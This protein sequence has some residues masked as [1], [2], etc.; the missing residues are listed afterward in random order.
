MSGSTL[1]PIAAALALV[2]IAACSGGS[3]AQV[4]SSAGIQPAVHR[5]PDAKTLVYVSQ[6][7]ANRISAFRLDGK[8]IGTIRK[9]VDYPQGIFADAQGT[10]YIANRGASDVLEFNRGA[11]SPSKIL[12]DDNE[13]PE[14]VTVCPDGTV[15]VANILGASGGAGDITVYAHASRNPTRTLNY[16]GGFF[17]FLTCDAQGNVFSTLVLGTTGTVVEF[18]GGQQSGATQLP[19]F[20]GGNP[21]GIVADNAGNLLVAGQGDGVEEFTESGSPTGLQIAATG[22]NQITLSPDGTLLL[23]ATAKGASQYTFPAGKL[24]H[25]YRSSGTAMGAAFDPGT[26]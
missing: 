15:Y 24:D 2:I 9:R 1:R 23:G 14:D 4:A 26:N 22:L 19:I 20:F 13:Q 16:N 17:F 10:L 8:R 25:T 21:S 12:S 3:S 5:P 6:E 7:A 18:P 11:A